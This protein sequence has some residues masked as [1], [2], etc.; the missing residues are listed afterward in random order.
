MRKLAIAI[1]LAAIAF[2]VWLAASI[3]PWRAASP[4]LVESAR[5]QIDSSDAELAKFINAAL[6]RTKLKVIYDGTYTLIAYPGGDVPPS[7][8][9]C[10]DEVIRTYRAVGID[11]QPLV[12]EDMKK[13]FVDYPKLWDL[14]APDL[15]IDHRRVPNLQTFFTR[16]GASLPISEDPADY[17]PGDLV[18]CMVR[19]NRPHI[20]IV[21]PAPKSGARPWIMHN[22]GF[23]PKMEDKLFAW[24]LTGHYRWH[25]V[26]H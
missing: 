26:A 17:R 6:D 19:G 15:H 23:G 24:K 3:L 13:N 1:I 20:A 16:H 11:L 25:P 8:G 14:K 5:L 21:V 9:V 18:T 12:H 7:I 2:G 10:T 4:D 22:C